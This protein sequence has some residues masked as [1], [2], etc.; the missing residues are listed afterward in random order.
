MKYLSDKTLASRIKRVH[1]GQR[2]D[3]DRFRE[4]PR[5]PGFLTRNERWSQLIRDLEEEFIRR[6]MHRAAEHIADVHH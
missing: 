2:E 5:G 1:R 4:N 6:C 3:K